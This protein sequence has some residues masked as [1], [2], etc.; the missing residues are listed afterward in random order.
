MEKYTDEIN[1]VYDDEK[2]DEEVYEDSMEVYEDEING[3]NH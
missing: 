1:G 2:T 3:L